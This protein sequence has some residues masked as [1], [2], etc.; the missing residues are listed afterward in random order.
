MDVANFTQNPASVAQFGN[1]QNTVGF[2]RARLALLG[3]Y[4]LIDYIIEMDFANRGINSVNQLEGPVHGLQGRVYPSARPARDRQCPRRS[5]QGM[6]WIGGPDERQ[7]HHVHGAVARRRRGVLP[8][9]QRRH[10]GVQLDRKPAGH[11]GHRRVHEPDRIRSAADVH[12]RPLGARHDDARHV[13]ALVRRGQRRPRTAPYRPR[14]RLPQRPGPHHDLG[15]SA[16]VGLRP[17][18]RQHDSD[19]LERH[20]GRGTPKRPWST[21]RS[22]C[23]RKFFASTAQ[24]PGRR[25]QQLLRNLRLS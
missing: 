9:P 20:A 23:S 14:L 4:E 24:S 19:R 16:R 1:A 13:S 8:R 12:L 7:L 5:L 17:V 6:L 3:E 22:P 18:G 11:L 25:Q 15:R 21:G 10:H 2:R